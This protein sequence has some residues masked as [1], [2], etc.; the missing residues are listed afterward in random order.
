MWFDSDKRY[1]DPD[2]RYPFYPVETGSPIAAA[3][4]VIC[5]VGVLAALYLT[6]QCP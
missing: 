3:I 1:D 2:E 6:R 4:L 5:V